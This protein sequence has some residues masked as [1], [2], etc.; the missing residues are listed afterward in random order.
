VNRDFVEM[1]SALSAEGVEHL[2]VGGWALAAHGHPRAT[3]DL[4]IYVRPTPENAARVMRALQRFGAPLFGLSVTEISSPGAILQIGVPP[5]RI[6]ITTVIDGVTFEEAWAGRT[7][8]RF[9]SVE[10]PVLGR[11][12]LLRNKRAVGRPQDVADVEVLERGT[13]PQD[14]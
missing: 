4:D 3:K 10:A 1:L 6:D 5:L 12:D 14:G 13:P 8:A 2:V 7:T 9:G 11:A